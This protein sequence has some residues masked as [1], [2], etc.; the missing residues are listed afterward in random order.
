[1]LSG[2]L[3]EASVPTTDGYFL[4]GDLGRL[5]E[6]DNLTIT[7][8]LKLLID[9]GGL[10]VNPLEVEEVLAQ[11]PGVSSCVVVPVRVSATVSRL[12]AIVTPDTA[13][14]AAPPAAGSL[15]AFARSR[16]RAT[17]CRGCSRCAIACRSRRR[18]RSSDIWWKRDA[19][20]DD[21]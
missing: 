18:A 3:G 5:D 2:Y 14:G 19:A 7:G 1:M 20:D 11:H 12:K 17:R 9:V 15:R 13:A 10:K 8:R 16:W 21:R 4:T 6:H